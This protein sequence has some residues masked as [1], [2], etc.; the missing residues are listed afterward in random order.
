MWRSRNGGHGPGWFGPLATFLALSVLT[1]MAEA[2]TDGSPD[3]PGRMVDVGTHRLHLL[4]EGEGSPTIVIDSGL[5]ALAFEWRTVQRTLASQFTTCIYDRA[6]YGWS[7][8]GPQPRTTARI[9]DELALLL[10]RAEIAGPY[11]LVGHSFGGYTAQLFA[12]RFPER[13]AGLVLVDASHPEQVKRYLESPLRMNTAPARKSGRIVYSGFTVHD[14]LPEEVRAAVYAVGFTPKARLAMTQEY[15]W[16]RDSA[17]EVAAAG[18]LPDRPLVVLT[19]GKDTAQQTGSESAARR[20]L[21]ELIWLQLQHEL[22]STVPRAAHI[23]AEHSGHQMH[24]EQPELVVDAIGMVADFARVENAAVRVETSP[25]NGW[26]S[27]RHAR[28]EVDRLHAS[29]LLDRSPIPPGDSSMTDADTQP[30]TTVRARH[31]SGS[32]RPQL[33]VVVY[34]ED[35]L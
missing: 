5:G 4:C 8:P 9:T 30:G 6:G 18:P 20:E 27:F 16:F 34:P 25:A 14:G 24:L 31:Y 3:A 15:L 35:P 1:P 23:V 12:R 10:E 22:A 2:R 11:V 26:L 19:R 17:A 28:W 13:T 7:E 29:H 33:Q 21:F 32:D